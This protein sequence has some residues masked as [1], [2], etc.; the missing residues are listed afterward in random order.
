MLMMKGLMGYCLNHKTTLDHIRAKA[1]SMED[2]LAELKAGR[3]FRRR[4]LLCQ[5]KLGVS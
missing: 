2:K 5:K 1:R 3:W 4:S